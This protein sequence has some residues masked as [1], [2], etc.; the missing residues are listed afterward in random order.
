MGSSSLWLS[1]PSALKNLKYLGLGLPTIVSAFLVKLPFYDFAAKI[2]FTAVTLGTGFKGGEVTP[3]FFI[4]STLGNALSHFFRCRRH[5]S[6]GWDSS[7]YS[8][9]RQYA[10]RLHL[11]GG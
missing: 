7:R 1:S 4:G 10:D 8:P 5:S 2:L 6:P 9:G 3:L 11:D